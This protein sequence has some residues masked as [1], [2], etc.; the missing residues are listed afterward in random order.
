MSLGAAATEL[1]EGWQVAAAAPGAVA[2][3]DELDAA[4]LDW[5]AATVPGTAASALNDLDRDYDAEDWWFRCGFAVPAALVGGPLVLELDGIATVSET[6]FNGHLVLRSESMW[7]EHAVDVGELAAADNQ[8]VIVCRA[9][10]PLTAKRRRPAARWRTR[11]VNN[12]NLRWYRTMVFGRS[13]GFAPAPAAV[14]PW[15]PVRLG[16]P[17]LLAEIAVTT[18]LDGSTGIVRVSATAADTVRANVVVGDADAPLRQT[19]DGR[20]QAELRLDDVA[21]W[22]PHTH[23]EPALHELAISVDDE[24]VAVRRIGFR[25]L[26]FPADIPSDGLSLELNDVPIFIRGAVWTPAD[27]VSLAPTDDE[28]RAILEQVRDAGMNMLRIAGTGAYESPAFHDLCD[29]LGILVWQDLDVRQPRLPGRR[30]AFS[31]EVQREASQVLGG[32]LIDPAWPSLCGGNEVAQQLAMIGL[33]PAPGDGAAVRRAAAEAGRA[34]RPDCATSPSRP[35]AA[36]CRSAPTAGSP[37]ITASAPTCGRST[38]R[39]APSAVRRRVPGLRQRARR[40]MPGPRA[41]SGLEA[42]RAPPALEARACRATSAR[43]GT[44]RTSATTISPALRRGPGGLRQPDHDRYLELSRAVTGEVMAEVIGE[45]RRAGS[46]ARARWS[47]LKDLQPG[48]RLGRDRPPRASPRSPSF[49]CAARWRR[50]PS[51]HRRGRRGRRRAR[52]HVARPAR[53]AHA[54]RHPLPRL[55]IPPVRRRHD[56]AVSGTALDGRCSS[57]VADPRTVHYDPHWAS[58]SARRRPM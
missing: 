21:R 26:W 5:T 10:A 15:R 40:R 3:A 6:Y 51:G 58:R 53:R 37:T 16:P 27:L 18:R 42:G 38:T 54:P 57:V 43:A 35:G 1:A 52:G 55:E 9:L 29:E 8:L 4:G 30:P 11:V 33:D 19:G 28:L 48:R 20:L 49:T 23:G 32:S 24:T 47:V 39:G 45:W 41:P 14:G 2:A 44:S 7:R 36:T 12:G 34:G 17:S 56:Q 25:T 46:L 22:W 31:A 13:P 50:S